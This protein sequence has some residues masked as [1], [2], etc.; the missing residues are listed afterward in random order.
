MFHEIYIVRNAQMYHA[1]PNLIISP[2]VDDMHKHISMLN[3]VRNRMISCVMCDWF[4][5]LCQ[6]WFTVT[7]IEIVS[8]NSNEIV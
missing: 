4:K 6:N 8:T 5:C 1:W 2:P 3:F 7:S